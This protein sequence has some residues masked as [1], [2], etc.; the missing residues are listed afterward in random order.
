VAIESEHQPTSLVTGRLLASPQL[1]W[2]SDRLQRIDAISM[3]GI[4]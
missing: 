3:C 2:N 1:R 4:L